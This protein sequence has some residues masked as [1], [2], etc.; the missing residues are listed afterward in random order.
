MSNHYRKDDYLE[1][2][3]PVHRLSYCAFLDVLG[4]SARIR[5]SYENDMGD[6]LLREFHGIFSNCLDKI[7]SEAGQSILYFKTFSDNVLLAYPC[8]SYDMES[9]FGFILWSIKEYQFEMA[10]HGFFIRGGL[11]VGN[12]F[13]DDNSVYGG[14]LIDAYELK[15][16]TAINPIVVLSA[17]A[18]KL[19]DH[20]IG[21]YS[22]EAAPQIRDVLISEDGNYFINYLSESIIETDAGEELDVESLR[23]H[24]EQIE[25]ALSLYAGQAPVFAKFSWL[26][27]YH[28]YFCDSVSA[29][30]E[31]SETLK[32]NNVLAS[33]KF[34]TIAGK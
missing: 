29:Y 10:L 5:S 23:K 14:A 32:V 22:G 16:K 12:L 31:Y 33:V 18:K 13:V 26:T 27:A 15:S 1:N 20:H 8:L 2:G 21:Y 3:Q 9:E 11:C 17:D 4:F 24:K 30:P 6:K 25:L 7:K 19:V 28:N 34:K